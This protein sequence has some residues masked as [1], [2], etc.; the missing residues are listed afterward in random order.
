MT[1]TAPCRSTVSSLSRCHGFQPGRMFG[2][3]CEKLTFSFWFDLTWQGA[4]A[5]CTSPHL[6]Q[7]GLTFLPSIA[8]PVVLETGAFQAGDHLVRQRCAED[9]GC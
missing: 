7:V 4:N 1:V 2:V 6:R 9:P 5:Q 8:E 3:I